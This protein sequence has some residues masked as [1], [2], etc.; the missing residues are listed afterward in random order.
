MP[1]E[2]TATVTYAGGATNGVAMN[3]PAD[4]LLPSISASIAKAMT[5]VPASK[6]GAL[7]AIVTPKGCNLAVVQKVAGG[8]NGVMVGADGMLHGAACWI[9]RAVPERAGLREVEGG[10]H[11][12]DDQRPERQ[13][14]P[15]ERTDEAARAGSCRG[16]RRGRSHR[17]EVESSPAA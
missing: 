9:R 10:R 1:P 11:G 2:S 3:S 5:A 16:G 8:M 12:Q 15:A 6:S 7:V 13:S 4:Y 17:H 14:D